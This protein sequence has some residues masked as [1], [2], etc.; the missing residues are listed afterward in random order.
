MMIEDK[1]IVRAIREK[2]EMGFR[3]LMQKYKQP[4]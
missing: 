4:I 2:S 3:L 1:D